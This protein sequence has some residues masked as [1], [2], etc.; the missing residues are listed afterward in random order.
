MMGSKSYEKIYTLKEIKDTDSHKFTI[1][2][3]NA[4]PTSETAEQ[5]S[6]GI[7]ERLDTTETYTGQLKLDLTTGKIEKYLEKLESEWVM[8]IPPTPETKGPVALKIG[9]IRLYRLEKI[10]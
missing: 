10:D 5:V 1:V 4:I 8:V 7:P 3:M 9:A 2:E 6:D